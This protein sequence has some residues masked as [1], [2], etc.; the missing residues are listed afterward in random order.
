MWEQQIAIAVIAE[1]IRRELNWG[2]GKT[3]YSTLR[4][5]PDLQDF[6]RRITMR[7]KINKS[8]ADIVEELTKN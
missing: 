4:E 2:D 8:V 1:L 3:L 7:P 6:I 5:A